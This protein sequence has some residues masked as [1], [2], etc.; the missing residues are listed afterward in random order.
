MPETFDYA[1]EGICPNRRHL[2][3]SSTPVCMA[4]LA[5]VNA[6]V[7]GRVKTRRSVLRLLDLAEERSRLTDC[8]KKSTPPKQLPEWKTAECCGRWPLPCRPSH[9][10][11]R[12]LVPRAIEFAQKDESAAR[13]GSK[14]FCLLDLGLEL[15][16]YPGHS[17]PRA[18]RLQ[19][20][21]SDDAGC[22]FGR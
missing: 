9:D 13:L 2:C 12:A 21:L 10:Q 4:N 1:C 14:V 11:A 20:S 15:E 16:R 3:R 6:A 8:S 7:S 22:C 17:R 5:G 19:A 18:R